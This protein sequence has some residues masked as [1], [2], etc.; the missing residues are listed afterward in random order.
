M[1]ASTPNS[2][3]RFLLAEAPWLPDAIIA[4]VTERSR[5]RV[6]Q[7]RRAMGLPPARVCQLAQARM[8]ISPRWTQ[9][10]DWKAALLGVKRLT[11]AES[12]EML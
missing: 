3:L 9:Q 6:G 1:K 2:T 8:I 10:E 4:E 7:V 12:L 5:S 11:G